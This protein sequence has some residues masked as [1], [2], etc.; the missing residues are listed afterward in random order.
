MSWT[1]LAR[2]DP[3]RGGYD[4]VVGWGAALDHEVIRSLE[5]LA[6]NWPGR[7]IAL[8]GDETARSAKAALSRLA[9]LGLWNLRTPG[10]TD[11]QG[12]AQL[13]VEAARGARG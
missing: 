3:W 4:A 13:V 8:V 2:L 7:A 1:A 6:P 10:G 9:D 12:T 11:W 5:Q